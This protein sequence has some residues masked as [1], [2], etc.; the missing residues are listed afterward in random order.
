MFAP[1][2]GVAEDPATGSAAGPLALHLARHGRIAF[3][4][5]IE[6]SQGVEIGRPLDALRARRRHGG[7]GRAHRGRRLGGDRRARRVPLSDAHRDHRARAAAARRRSRRS[8]RGRSASATSR[9]TRSITGRTGSRAAPS[10]CAS[11]CSPRPRA[12]AG[13]TDSTYHHM[14]GTLVVRSR[15]RP[16]LA[17]PADPAR[18]VAA[19]AADA[20]RATATRSSSGTA[21]SSPAGASRRA[22]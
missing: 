16:R 18:H 3:G 2:L 22:I 15:R 17:R 11:A 7:R 20:R 10:R 1:A 12:T 8:S 14:L 9:S 13:S 4:D 19:A 5:E 21:T 6:I